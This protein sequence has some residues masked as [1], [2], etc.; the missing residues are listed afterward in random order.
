MGTMDSEGKKTPP[1]HPWSWYPR[2]SLRLLII[3]VMAIGIGL[4][5]LVRSARIQ[6]EAVTAIQK[7]DGFILY[8]WEFEMPDLAP[9]NFC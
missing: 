8:N 9:A 2:F 1:K 5:W 6:R 3:A 4:G 7:A